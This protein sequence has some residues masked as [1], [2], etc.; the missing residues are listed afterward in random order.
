MCLP[1]CRQGMIDMGITDQVQMNYVAGDVT[2]HLCE[3]DPVAGDWI[4]QK[5][6]HRLL[7]AA[8]LMKN[9]QDRSMTPVLVGEPGCGKTRLACCAAKEFERPVYIMSCTSDMQPEDLIVI[10]VLSSDQKVLYRGSPLVSA[11]VN[12]GVCVLDEANRMNE[13]CWA[14]LAALLDDRRS[15]QSV[16]A[17]IKIPAHPEFRLVATMNEDASTYIIPDY[18]ESRLRP[19]LPIDLPKDAELIEIVA[20]NVPFVPDVLI[21]A[22]VYY[23]AEKKKAGALAKYSIRDA[24]LIT[25]YAAR[26]CD[27]PAF[28]IAGTVS[29]FLKIDGNDDNQTS[30]CAGNNAVK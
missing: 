19:I 4:G 7:C 20:K 15:V 16:N 28:S 3:P 6:V 22:I 2:I 11:V 12:G 29:K 14:S 30:I 1:E 26:F 25:R 5:E 27:D 8:W 24:I 21:E 23:L 18:I 13:K 17:G 10:P 9:D